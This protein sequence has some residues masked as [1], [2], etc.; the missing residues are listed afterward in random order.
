MDHT[1]NDFV[2]GTCEV[3]AVTFCVFFSLS[4][5]LAIICHFL[6]EEKRLVKYT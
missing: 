5:L 3:P 2:S 4:P 6:E 1:T